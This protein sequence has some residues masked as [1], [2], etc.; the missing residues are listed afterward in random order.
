[1]HS[2]AGYFQRFVLI[3]Q[4]LVRGSDA[5]VAEQAKASLANL[6]SLIYLGQPPTNNNGNPPPSQLRA[7]ASVEQQW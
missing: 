2:N 5:A 3:L 4:T 6:Q 1:M 7:Q